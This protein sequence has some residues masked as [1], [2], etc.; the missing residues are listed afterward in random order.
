MIYPY[1]VRYLILARLGIVAC[2]ILKPEIEFLTKDD[3]DFV[4]REYLEFALHEYSDV[5]RQKV[6]ETVNALE[7]EVD[8]VLLGYARC[9]S[10][11]GITN[12]LKVPT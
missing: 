4:H 2:D 7:G 1:L 8:A 5:L 3:P 9:Q 6:T 12:V 10:L 11:D